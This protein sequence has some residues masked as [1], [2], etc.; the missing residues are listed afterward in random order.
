MIVIIGI[1]IGTKKEF[2]LNFGNS[3]NF[4][5]FI[6]IKTH[7]F[8]KQ[9]NLRFPEEIDNPTFQN[10]LINICIYLFDLDMPKCKKKIT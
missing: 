1:S 9:E 7:N 2:I 4:M 3:V 8:S 6:F 5:D 10:H